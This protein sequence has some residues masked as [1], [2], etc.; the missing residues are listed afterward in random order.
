MSESEAEFSDYKAV[1]DY[2]SNIIIS[3]TEENVYGLLIKGADKWQ[4]ERNSTLP[5]VLY[6]ETY[7]FRFKMSVEIAKRVKEN[8]EILFVGSII[9]PYTAEGYWRIAPTAKY[10][11][12]TVTNNHLLIFNLEKIMLF[13]TSSGKI[14]S[15]KEFH[16]ED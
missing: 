2:G 4:I 3:K 11:S 5:L 10:P 16:Q 14:V 13:D 9:E 8:L 15:T 1:T 6:S 7:N 12:E